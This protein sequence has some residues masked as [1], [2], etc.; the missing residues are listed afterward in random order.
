MTWEVAELVGNNFTPIF[1]DYYDFIYEK[2]TSGQDTTAFVSTKF[3]NKTTSIPLKGLAGHFVVCGIRTHSE[4]GIL[5]NLSG[6]EPIYIWDLPLPKQNY[7]LQENISLINPRK[8]MD[9]H[10]LPEADKVPTESV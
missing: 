10:Q 7:L 5:G 1:P 6:S 3:D 4:Q 9:D 2:D 8:L